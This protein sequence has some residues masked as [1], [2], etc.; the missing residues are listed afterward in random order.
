MEDPK[1]ELN[2]HPKM[3][4]AITVTFE[5]TPGPF[6]SIEASADY[7]VTNNSCVPEQPL[8]GARLLP[9]KRVHLQLRRITETTYETDMYVDLIQDEDYY[10]KGVCRWSLAA[11]SVSA[12]KQKMTFITP[13]SGRNFK[14][15]GVETRYFSFSSYRDSG[16]S[17]RN[18]GN[19]E[20]SAYPD[21]SS[22]FSVRVSAA[23][24]HQ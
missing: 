24:M 12:R 6:D 19:K 23:E 17:L 18:M 16:E 9:N 21:P 13:L 4:Y 10:S 22:T 8:S 2:P 11:V 3:R 15:P 14:N 20:R 5:N 7:G 1:I